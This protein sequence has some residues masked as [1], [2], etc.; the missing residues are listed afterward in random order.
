MTFMTVIKCQKPLQYGYQINR[1]DPNI[2]NKDKFLFLS[3]KGKIKNRNY[4]FQDFPFIIPFIDLN[5]QSNLKMG[6][7]GPE[8]F[9]VCLYL[10]TSWENIMCTL[11]FH[12]KCFLTRPTI[13]SNLWSGWTTFL[14]WDEK[15]T[16]FLLLTGIFKSAN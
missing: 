4:F 1:L 15:V 5:S 9:W 3:P 11:I 16:F 10:Y 7:L 8:I 13:Y 6:E 2:S 14:K 12:K